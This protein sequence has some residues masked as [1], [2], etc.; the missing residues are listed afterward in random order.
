VASQTDPIFT[1]PAPGDASTGVAAACGDEPAEGCLTEPG[2]ELG[3][4]AGSDSSHEPTL[5][6]IEAHPYREMFAI[7]APTIVTMTSYTVMQFIDGYMVT[8]IDEDPVYLAA[9]GNG[10]IVAWLTMSLL[11]GLTT[12]VNSYVSQNLGA[13]KP[14]EGAAYAWNAIWLSIAGWALIMLPMLAIAPMIYQALGHDDRLR[15]LETAYAQI[16]LAGGVLTLCGRALGHYFYGMHRPTV[17]MVS[18]LLGNLVNIFA[19]W[20]LI[21]GNLGAPRLGVAGAALGTVIGTSFELVIPLVIFLG[22]RYA[23]EFA[24]RAAWRLSGRHLADI[25]RIG[26]PGALMFANEMACWTYLMVGLIPAAARSAGQNPVLANSAGWIGL[27]YMHLSFMPTVGL[28]IAVTAI[29]GK[30]M[31]M[32]RPE[33]AASRTWLAFRLGL[34][35]MGVCGVVFFFFRESLVAVF[36]SDDTAPEDRAQIIRFGSYVLIAAAIFQLFDAI[37]I[38]LSGALR[39]AGD[40]V[41]PGVATLA[42]SWTCIVGGGHLLLAVAPDLGAMSPWIGAAAFLIALG[43]AMLVR[44]CSGRWRTMRLVRDDEPAPA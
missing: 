1:D 2:S 10:G 13:G 14:R 15:S 39:G 24:T 40:T 6:E 18:V 34:L 31:G 19:N 33:L 32:K 29:V 8:R 27:R 37:A 17:V 41:W 4:G 21:F 22:P 26:W 28:S 23:R 35:Y 25:F 3:L 42:L 44:F 36:I 12:V 9:Q 43:L 16:V 11:L 38:I 7:A 5:A 30:C 20:V